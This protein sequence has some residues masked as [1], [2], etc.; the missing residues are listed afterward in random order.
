[1]IVFPLL[2]SEFKVSKSIGDIVFVVLTFMALNF[3]IRKLLVIF[4]L[5]IAAVFYYL[6]LGVAGLIVNAIVLLLI[7]RFFPEKLS[8]PGFFPALMGGFLLSVANFFT[9]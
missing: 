3:I 9:S 1:M 7:S 5:G 6:S 8:V 2:N 4:T